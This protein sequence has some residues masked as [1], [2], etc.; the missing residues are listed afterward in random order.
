MRPMCSLT[1]GRSWSSSL[2]TLMS[3]FKERTRDGSISGGSMN[4]GDCGLSETKSNGANE[5]CGRRL[6]VWGD[7]QRIFPHE[8]KATSL[9]S[10]V[11]SLA[12]LAGL[13]S[14]LMWNGMGDV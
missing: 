6:G 4:I 9:P 8:S 11:Q 12:G 5:S 13:G 2:I 7:R 14:I 10:Q 1:S 3:T